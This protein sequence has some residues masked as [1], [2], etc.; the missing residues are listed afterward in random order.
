MGG[1]VV[2]R[3]TPRRGRVFSVRMAQRTLPRLRVTDPDLL[4]RLMASPARETPWGTRELASTLGVSPGTITNLRSGEQRTVSAEL[5]VR[6]A[7]AL[8]VETGVLF[9][10]DVVSESYDTG[11]TA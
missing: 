6:F 11:V 5:A 1:F 9:R 10:A 8:G 2:L 7:E 4:R 3:L